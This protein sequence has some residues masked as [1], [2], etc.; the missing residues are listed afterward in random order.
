MD[1]CS[2]LVTKT[3]PVRVNGE[4]KFQSV[5][6]VDKNCT[7]LGISAR[8]IAEREGSIGFSSQR[9]SAQMRAGIC[10]LLLVSFVFVPAFL[11]TLLREFL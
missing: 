2:C 8:I 6:V 5:G 10:L 4:K 1:G 9:Q 7:K 3:R 11:T